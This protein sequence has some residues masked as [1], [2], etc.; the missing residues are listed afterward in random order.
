MGVS[1]KARWLFLIAQVLF[2][3]FAQTPVM[4]DAR[5]DAAKGPAT[6]SASSDANNAALPQRLAGRL[7]YSREQRDRM[8]RAR[9]RGDAI[10]GITDI[11]QT[12]SI[13]NGFVKRSDGQTMI[14][15]DG[16][17]RYNSTS[18][19]LANLRPQDVGS[20]SDRIEVLARGTQT[21]PPKKPVIKKKILGVSR[22]KAGIADKKK[23]K[24]KSVE[25]R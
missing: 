8:D 1:M 23:T 10:P 4:L 14:W 7:F 17:P 21:S 16:Q 24:L 19:E 20:S 5:P 2:S 15:V 11:A 13:L 6:E 18:R 22:S 3:A 12:P 9:A 25:F